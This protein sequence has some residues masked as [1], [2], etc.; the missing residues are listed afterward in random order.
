MLTLYRIYVI[1]RYLIERESIIL[2]K[3]RALSEG[4]KQALEV[5]KNAEGSVTLADIKEVFEGA[6]SS[7]LTALV[8]RGLVAT[9]QVVKEV[10]TIVKRKVN[11]Y[12][13]VAKETE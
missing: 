5:V 6:N 4:A 7:H 13:F 8:N 3:E 9:E 2:A 10:P 11:A 12:T 1:I